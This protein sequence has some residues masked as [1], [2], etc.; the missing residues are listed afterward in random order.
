MDRRYLFILIS[1]I[2][3]LNNVQCDHHINHHPIDFLKSTNDEYLKHEVTKTTLKTNGDDVNA[4]TTPTSV[5]TSEEP[6]GLKKFIDDVKNKFN[7][8]HPVRD[9]KEILFGSP[10]TKTSTTIASTSVPSTTEEPKK[11]KSHIDKIIDSMPSESEDMIRVVTLKEDE[12]YGKGKAKPKYLTMELEKANTTEYVEGSTSTFK[13]T[14]G[15]SSI[16]DFSTS[17]EKTTQN[18]FNGK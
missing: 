12:Q 1:T 9:V 7:H 5:N 3:Y 11:E 10:Q 15:K 17:T 14:T 2:F 6:S 13:T 8:V 4:A 18:H 16:E